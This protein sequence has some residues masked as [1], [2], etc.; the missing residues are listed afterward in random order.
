M[1]THSLALKIA[2]SGLI[3]VLLGAGVV[4]ALSDPWETRPLLT[5]ITLQQPSPV[6]KKYRV[7]LMYEARVVHG[8][9]EFTGETFMR[10]RHE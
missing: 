2:L 1:N 4:R 9:A 8:K 7:E 5:A 6:F 3:G 10:S